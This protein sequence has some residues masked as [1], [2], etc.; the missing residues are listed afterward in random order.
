MRRTLLLCLVSCLCLP[1]AINAQNNDNI[2]RCH[3]V[4]SDAKLRA[5]HPELGTLEEFEHWLAPKVAAYQSGATERAVV[6]IP[7][8]FHIIHDN[9][10]VG[11]GDNL[12][13]V[14]INAQLDQLNNDFRRVLGTSGYNNNAV[15]ADT[16]VEFCAALVDENGNTLS[17]PGI[18]RINRNSLGWTAPPYGTCTGGFNDA[19]IEGTIKPQSQWD[20]DEYFNFWVMDIDCGILGYAQF[21]SSS[22]LGGLNTNGGSA[23]T[24][25][26]VCLTS[27]IG[28]TSTPNPAG[29]SYNKGRT[30][31][32]EVGHWIGLRHIW[33]DGGCSVDDFCGDTPTSDGANYGCPNTTSCGSTDMVENYMDYTDDD[34]MNIFTLNQKARMQAVL[35]NSPRRGSLTSSTACGGGNPGGGLS[36]GTTVSSFPYSESFESSLGG[37]TQGS[38][39]DFDWARRSGTTPSSN[40]GPSSA[41]AGSFYAYVE[42]SNPNN[43]SKQTILV[44]PCFDLSGTSSPSFSF[45][46]HMYG[47]AAMGDLNLQASTDGASWT[48]LWSESGNQGNAWASQTVSLSAYSGTVQLRFVG[49]TGSTWQGDI[50]IDDISLTTGGGNPGGGLTCGSTITS[51]PYSAGF[52]SNLSGW[53]QG[54]GDDFDWARRSG[55]TPSSNTGPSSAAAGSF[56]AYIESSSPN[57]PA[58]QAVLVSP[59][60]NLNGVS[61]PT[62]SFE[63]H[64]YGAA[65]M[66]DLNL[67]ASTNGTTWSSVWSESGNQGNAWASATVDLSSYAG[68]TVQLRFVGTTGTTW[69]G[70]M[71]IDDVS[72]TSGGSSGGCN[73]VNISLTFDDYPEETSWQIATTSGTVVASGGTYASQADRSTLALTECLPDGC[74]NFTINDAYGDGI[75]CSYGNGSYSVTNS[76][77]TLASGGSFGSSETTNFCV[78]GGSREIGETTTVWDNSKEMNVYPNPT[79]ANLNVAFFQKEAAQVELSVMNIMGK[80]V[81]TQR[82]NANDGLNQMELAVSDLPAGTYM[83]LVADNNVKQTQQFVVIK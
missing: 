73:T 15:G 76:G 12:S 48:S 33:G 20:P 77:T 51:F 32:H 5:Q 54:S 2:I 7:I 47:A 81:L 17:E 16:E 69:Q 14:Y 39:D 49:S 41:A 6:T 58:K 34:C 8:I 56:Y 11:S 61:S 66:G 37:W 35:A 75:C 71:A 23:N 50:A 68:S 1:L 40:T 42:A 79:R 45:E 27:S 36:C 72:L 24:D 63:Y 44:S 67:E 53:T 4:E 62:F 60:F 30:A 82:F 65:A 26:V 10:A 13:A 21:P 64:M 80:V 29:G 43:P 57:Y 18:N 70:D 55:T 9:D 25:G 22:G 83:L 46:Y 74:Y 31:T 3:T 52:E 59:C 19:Y 78:S 28:S 38:G